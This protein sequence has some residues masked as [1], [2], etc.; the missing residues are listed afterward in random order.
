MKLVDARI[1]VSFLSLFLLD[2]CTISRCGHNEV[3]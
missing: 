3:C 2:E 1:L